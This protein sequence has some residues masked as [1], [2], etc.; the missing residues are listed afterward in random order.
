MRV[1]VDADRLQ[2]DPRD[3]RAPTGGH[4]QPVAP[5]VRTAV[6]LQDILLTVPPRGGGVHPEHQLDPVPAQGL[7]ER[8]TQRRRLA[9]KHAVGA[10]DE[11]RLAAQ[12][13]HDLGHLDAHR[14][15]TQHQQATRDRLHPGGLAV[16]PHAVELTQAR[17]RW[18]D[19]I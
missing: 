9:G 2:A 7:A 4:Q 3:A 12:A 16:G 6:E 5:Q 10:L 15:A 1:G 14:P 18:H 17:D 19:R 11:H 8:L 13:A